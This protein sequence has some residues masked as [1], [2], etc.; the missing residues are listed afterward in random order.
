MKVS[1][2]SYKLLPFVLACLAVPLF[3]QRNTGAITGIVIDENGKPISGAEIDADEIVQGPGSKLIR[4][5]LS[6]SSGLFRFEPVK[7]GSYK[8]FGLKPESW[9]PDTKF[10]LY[11]G[12]YH[13]VVV[14]LSTTQPSA[15]TTLQLGPKSGIVRLTILDQRELRPVTNSVVEIRRVGSDVWISTSLSEEG[16]ILVPPDTPVQLTVRAAGFTPQKRG[17]PNEPQSG[18]PVS[19]HSGEELKINMY[20]VRTADVPQP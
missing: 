8:L 1:N 13:P 12:Q 7:F 2:R 11:V 3:A 10:E 5:A 18:P 6:D 17:D 9:Y 20:L 4:L 15:N 19:L 16:T 14:T